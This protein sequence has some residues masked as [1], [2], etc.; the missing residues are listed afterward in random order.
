MN[1][2]DYQALVEASW[3]RALTAEEQAQLDAWLATRPETSAAW[4]TEIGLNQLLGQLPDVPISSNFTAQAWQ[5]VERDVAAEARRPS[6]ADRIQRW[7][8]RP[9]PRIAWTAVLLVAAWFGYHQH[10]TSVRNDMAQ[11]LAVMASVAT[12]SDPTVLQEFD[13][14]QR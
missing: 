6:L 12:L 14:I 10:Q 2:S 4:E 7:F 9:T 8:R 3:R 1:E 11:G 13:A 5:A